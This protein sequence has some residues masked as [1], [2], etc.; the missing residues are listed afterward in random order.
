[1]SIICLSWKS[2][3]ALSVT[4][5]SVSSNFAFVPFEVEARAHFA[6]RLVDGV[7]DFVRIELGNDVEGW[8]G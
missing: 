6:V 7:R 8:H 4:T 5:R 1:M 2:A 3:G